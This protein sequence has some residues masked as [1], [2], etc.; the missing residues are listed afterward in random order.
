[1]D[2]N[3]SRPEQPSGL[4]ANPQQSIASAF[5]TGRPPALVTFDVFDTLIWRRTLYPQDVFL[6]LNR[7]LPGIASWM[8]REAE[9][10]ATFTCRRILR[11]EPTLHDIYHLLPMNPAHE[12]AIEGRVCMANPHCHGAIGWLSGRGA[13]IAAVSDMYLDA[14]EIEVLLNACGYPAMPVYSSAT[15]GCTKGG[16]GALFSA[17]WGQ[18][19]VRPSEVLHIGDN[20]HSDIAMAMRLGAATCHV[21]TPRAT[22]SDV[23]PAV[24]RPNSDAEALFWGELAIRLH[25]HVADNKEGTARYGN[26]IRM[27]V[28]QRGAIARLSVDDFWQE[29]QSCAE[30]VGDAEAGTQRAA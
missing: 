27:L 26:A 7:R 21:S 23:Y 17:I 1:M 10:V 18:L 30:A 13:R 24:P 3:Y 16:N 12:I 6:S 28:Q 14:R 29:I 19:G 2:G 8:R 5:A 25:L 4:V 11:R 20:A 22:L 9:R 15:E